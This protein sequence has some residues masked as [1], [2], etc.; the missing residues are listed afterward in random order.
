MSLRHY[1]RKRDRAD[2]APIADWCPVC[3]AHV[4]L[5]CAAC[6]LRRQGTHPTYAEAPVE[7]LYPQLDAESMA[8]MGRQR[9]KSLAMK[10]SEGR[11]RRPKADAI[12]AVAWW[13]AAVE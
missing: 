10:A 11:G 7:D 2:D 1:R 6:Q 4:E 8:E 9:E 3:R 12:G 13:V 5:P